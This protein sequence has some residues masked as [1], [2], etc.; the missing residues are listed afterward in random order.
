MSKKRIFYIVF[1]TC[2]VIGFFLAL[3]F[4]IPGFT[5][6]NFPPISIVQP[7]SFLDENGKAITEKEIKG[8]VAVVNFFFTTCRGICPR[9]NN[10]LKPLYETFKHDSDFV[11]LSHTCDPERDSV[12]RLKHY[13]DSMQVDTQKWMFLTG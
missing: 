1:F 8:K 10:N 6:Q 9:M 7:F 4:F 11:I 2:L 3:S 5:K 13:A 12:S